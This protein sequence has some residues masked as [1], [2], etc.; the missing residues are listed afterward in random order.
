MVTRGSVRSGG[1]DLALQYVRLRIGATLDGVAVLFDP[2]DTP[3]LVLVGDPGAGKTTTVRF[4]ARWWTANPDRHVHVITDAWH[5]WADVAGAP[6][7]NGIFRSRGTV[8][9][10]S[11][12]VGRRF[13]GCVW[14]GCLLIADDLPVERLESVLR[15]A[16][17]R[18][19]PVIATIHGVTQLPASTRLHGFDRATVYAALV[20]GARPPAGS[21]DLATTTSRRGVSFQGRLDWPADAIPVIPDPRGSADLPHHPWLHTAAAGAAG[22]AAAAVPLHVVDAHHPRVSGRRL[23]RDV[24]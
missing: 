21:P 12:L 24:S 3:L 7:T 9:E 1:P 11:R 10:A 5:E 15:S 22:S 6:A 13:G 20:P 2:S 23:C 16:A 18:R 17:S 8:H 4:I 14:D 19:T